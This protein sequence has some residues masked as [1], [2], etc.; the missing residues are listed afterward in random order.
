MQDVHAA[1]LA[2]LSSVPCRLFLSFSLSLSLS[3]R[4]RSASHVCCGEQKFH[5]PCG[6]ATRSAHPGE[7]RD[8][9][10]VSLFLSSSSHGPLAARF[11]PD[12]KY[13][14]QRVTLKMRFGLLPAT[15][16]KLK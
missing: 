13:S 4:A 14:R 7:R 10:L 12:D 8:L 5:E 1:G 9:S 6:K 15:G 11:S 3:A 2:P 16:T